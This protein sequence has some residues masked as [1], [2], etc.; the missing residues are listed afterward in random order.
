MRALSDSINSGNIS[1]HSDKITDDAFT[2]INVQNADMI[3]QSMAPQNV[4]TGRHSSLPHYTVLCCWVR[5]REPSRISFKTVMH[6]LKWKV[7][8]S[9]ESVSK[10]SKSQFTLNPYGMS[11]LQII[12]N[13]T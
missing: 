3:N 6:S 5:D 9:E 12:R 13:G 1:T 2:S 11:S 10:Y 7:E 4:H 8:N